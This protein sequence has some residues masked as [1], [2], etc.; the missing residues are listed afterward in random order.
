MIKKA[1]TDRRVQSLKRDATLA[2]ALGHYD[3]WDAIV[4][5]LGVRTSATGRRTFVLMTRFPG[6][7]NPT[8]RALGTYG[9][10]SLE[11]ARAK[12]RTW[13]ELIR[14]GVDPA[15]AEAERRRASIRL[16]ENT[17][18]AV[19]EDYLRLQ[20]IGLDPDRPRQRKAHTVARDF[21]TIFV[22]VWGQRP[23]TAITGTMC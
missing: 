5:G 11:Q 10:L 1:L 23:L 19:A 22:P 9:E 7:K 12:A 6:S 14:Q 3:V 2:D 21:R 16:R 15:E 20:V 13:L 4:P 8:R 18:A 17:F